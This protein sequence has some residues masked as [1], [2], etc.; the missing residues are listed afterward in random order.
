MEELLTRE[1][2][3]INDALREVSAATEKKLVQVCSNVEEMG[4]VLK[5]KESEELNNRVV[6]VYREIDRM[7]NRIEGGMKEIREDVGHVSRG[8]AKILGLIESERI[9]E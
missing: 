3:R 2:T 5:E 6:E 4:K 7:R 9:E 8:A 1:R